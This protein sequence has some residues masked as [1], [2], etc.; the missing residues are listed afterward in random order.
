MKLF[1]KIREFQRT[2]FGLPVYV[3]GRTTYTGDK[4]TIDARVLVSLRCLGDYRFR[5]DK[6]RDAVLEQRRQ[7][8]HGA[9]VHR[10][11]DHH[12]AAGDVAGYRR[13]AGTYRGQRQDVASPEAVDLDLTIDQA[14]MV[15]ATLGATEGTVL[16]TRTT[17]YTYPLERGQ[18][19]ALNRRIGEAR[20]ELVT[21]YVRSVGAVQVSDVMKVFQW[22]KR[23]MERTIDALVG[24]GTLVSGLEVEGQKGTWISLPEL[25]G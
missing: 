1:H 25:A 20:Q 17:T 4:G 22:P 14:A 9:G 5:A 12:H 16:V 18:A 21:L 15:P 10:C 11:G 3:S 23:E 8:L 2:E 7:P 24:A 13:D 19:T 6:A